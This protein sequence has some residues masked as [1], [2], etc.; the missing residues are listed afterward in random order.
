MAPAAS[1]PLMAS[2]FFTNEERTWEEGRGEVATVFGSGAGQ[3][4]A[5]RV[6]PA[7]RRRR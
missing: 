4:G 5:R 6:R 1:K 2:R 3:P 7:A